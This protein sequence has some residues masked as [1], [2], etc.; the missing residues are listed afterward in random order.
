MKLSEFLKDKKLPLKIRDSNWDRHKFFE[1][2]WQ[3][4]GNYVGY[5]ERGLHL[6]LS[7]E[8][9]GEFEL[10]DGFSKPKTVITRYLWADT[11][12]FVTE[13]MYSEEEV[14]TQIITHY[15]VKD[16]HPVKLEWSRTEFYE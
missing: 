8:A 11:Q 3:N 2:W 7:C 13:K 16:T 10:Y 4:H 14:K 5:C 1:V 9:D 15:L 6:H 12:G